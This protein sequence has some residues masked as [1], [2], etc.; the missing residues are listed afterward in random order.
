MKKRI[1][2]ILLSALMILGTVLLFASCEDT[3]FDRAVER[4]EDLDKYEATLTLQFASGNTV[5]KTVVDM[6]IKNPEAGNDKEYY[7]IN[8]GAST[9]ELFKDGGW[10]YAPAIGS[11]I[12]S[13]NFTNDTVNGT[14]LSIFKE[15]L[16]ETVQELPEGLS[17]DAGVTED[18]DSYILAAKLTASEISDDYEDAIEVLKRYYNLNGA[19]V[20][21]AEIRV[22]VEGR[23][24]EEYELKVNFKLNGQIYTVT[25]LVEYDDPGDRVE[26]E[27]PKGYEDY[28]EVESIANELIK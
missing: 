24:V 6:K 19:T 20:D 8:T 22:V 15:I 1:T 23:Y 26:I 16:E 21:S 11:K 14:N 10:Y 7:K 17:K 12:S 2:L 9:I 3:K 18:D 28:K 27:F 25:S 4:T 13:R 5:T